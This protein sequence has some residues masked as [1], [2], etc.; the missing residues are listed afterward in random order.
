VSVV[1]LTDLTL[2][3][4]T[5]HRQT[6]SQS[7]AFVKQ[8]DSTLPVFLPRRFFRVVRRAAYDANSLFLFSWLVIERCSEVLECRLVGRRLAWH[9]KCEPP[10]SENH[11]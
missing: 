5:E 2:H 7:A 8:I 6:E 1:K 3:F 4:P 9:R 10:S 11:L